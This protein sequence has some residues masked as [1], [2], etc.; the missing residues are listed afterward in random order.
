MSGNRI[1]EIKRLLND[2]KTVYVNDLSRRLGVS[3]VSIR[4]YLTRLDHEG[5]AQRFYGGAS[6]I[7]TAPADGTDDDIYADPVRSALAR[8]ARTH[9]SEGDSIFIGSGRSCCILAREITG[10]SDLTVFTNNITAL[11]DL[12][13]NATRVYLLGGEVTSTDERTLFSSWDSPQASLENVYVHKAFTSI[14]G[15]D[16]KAGLTVD[17][18]ISIPIFRQIPSMAHRWYLMADSSKFDKI[19]IYPVADL[20]DVHTLISDAVPSRYESQLRS[21]DV[22]IVEFS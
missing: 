11:P 6:I 8:E 21:V 17:S 9:I 13:T 22:R 14:S 16:I 15:I 18:M 5:Y 1:D 10:F 12:L 4:K 19:S 3:R 20:S 7:E 2:R